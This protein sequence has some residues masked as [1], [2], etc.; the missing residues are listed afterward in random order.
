MAAVLKY[1]RIQGKEE[2]QIIKFPHKKQGVELLQEAK[3][4][5]A[6]DPIEDRG[7]INKIVLYCLNNQRWRD[8]LLFVLG[9]NFGMRVSDLR[10]LQIRHLIQSGEI[11]DSFMFGEKKTKKAQTIYINKAARAMIEIYVEETYRLTEESYLFPN[12]SRNKKIVEVNGQMV[13]A[14][15]TRQSIDKIIK[16][17]AKDMEVDGHYATHT[18]RKTP[19]FQVLQMGSDYVGLENTVGVQALQVFYGHSSMQ[20]TFHYTKFAE[21]NRRE[22]FGRLNLG[23]EA[24]M[25]FTEKKLGK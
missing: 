16:S 18:L 12:E 13:V 9:V 25:E 17:L 6:S 14:P 2:T 8:A 7:D 11:R 15:L 21:K 4:S 3:K 22:L 20:S 23:L 19:G 5:T 24:I 10:L 1:P